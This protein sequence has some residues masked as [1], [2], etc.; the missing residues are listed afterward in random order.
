MSIFYSDV[1]CEFFVVLTLKE[2]HKTDT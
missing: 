1:C 2:K